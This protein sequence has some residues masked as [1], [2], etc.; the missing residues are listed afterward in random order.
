MNRS[1][2]K[3]TK[4]NAKSKT[5]CCS[6]YTNTIS[7]TKTVIVSKNKLNDPK[8]YK[9]V[10]ENGEEQNHFSKSDLQNQKKDRET[11]RNSWRIEINNDGDI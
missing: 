7:I 3:N 5:H 4:P 6:V 9:R 1:R 8:K 2:I 10:N 11:Y